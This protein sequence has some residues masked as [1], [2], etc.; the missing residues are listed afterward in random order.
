MTFFVDVESRSVFRM[1][2]PSEPVTPVSRTV[3]QSVVE[4]ERD[5]ICGGTMW[6]KSEYLSISSFIKSRSAELAASTSSASLI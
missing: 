1:W 4:E 6:L 2:Q 5:W 3:L